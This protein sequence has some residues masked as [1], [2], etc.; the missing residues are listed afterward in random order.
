MLCVVL[1]APVVG[2]CGLPS[3]SLSVSDGGVVGLGVGGG[4]GGQGEGGA[5]GGGGSDDQGGETAK[6]EPRGG[7]MAKL[8]HVCRWR[9]RNGENG[10]GKKVWAPWPT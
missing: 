10:G 1:L 3:S 4:E 2:R 7:K 5:E 8:H 6:G 9:W